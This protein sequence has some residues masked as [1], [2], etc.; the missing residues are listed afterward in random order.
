[1][2]NAGFGRPERLTR[3]VDYRKVKERGVSYSDGLF[4][5]ARLKNDLGRHR[6]GMAI[7]S[8][9]IPY[10]CRRNRVRR[11]IREYFRQNKKKMGGIYYDM[12]I[13]VRKPMGR[14]ISYG[15][16]ENRLTSL[17]KR[18]KIS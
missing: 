16:I 1:M 17:L 11:L 15:F 10:A 8:S 6:L 13:G 5:V 9:K 3:N 18:A 2:K 7:G 14:E 4:F 12:V